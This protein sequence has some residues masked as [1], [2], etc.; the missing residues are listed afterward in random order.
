MS[1]FRCFLL[2]ILLSVILIFPSV[3]TMAAGRTGTYE[4]HF[5]GSAADSYRTVVIR[6][7]TKKKVVFQILYARSNPYKE[8]S[9]EKIIGKRKGNTVIFT[10]QEPWWNAAGTGTMKLSKNHI[11]IKTMATKGYGFIS[12]DG[13]A[14]Q[15]KRVSNKKK[16]LL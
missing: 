10:Y 5:V 11:K 15:L 6:K 16:L 13:Q 14:F 2:T 12:T 7:I 9:T 8:S 3:T 1:K 4:K